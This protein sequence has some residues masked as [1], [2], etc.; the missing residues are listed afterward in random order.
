MISGNRLG[1][2]VSGGGT[3]SFF[4]ANQVHILSISYRKQ[5]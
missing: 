3:K 1:S 2:F 5:H 4:Y